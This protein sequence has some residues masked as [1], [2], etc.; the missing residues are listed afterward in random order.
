MVQGTYTVDSERLRKRRKREWEIVKVRELD[1]EREREKRKIKQKRK[2]N[3]RKNKIFQNRRKMNLPYVTRI[4][5]YFNDSGFLG[6]SV[7]QP[8]V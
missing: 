7:G 2:I 3:K 5:V 8:S 6:Y 4:F 1:R